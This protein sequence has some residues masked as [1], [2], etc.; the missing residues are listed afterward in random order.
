MK[1][2]SL[3][4]KEVTA[5]KGHTKGAPRSGK[6]GLSYQGNES[7]F[8]GNRGGHQPGSSGHRGGRGSGRGGQQS[9]GGHSHPR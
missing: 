8:G 4:F 5:V 3:P 1:V 7:D 2:P 6:I 9:S